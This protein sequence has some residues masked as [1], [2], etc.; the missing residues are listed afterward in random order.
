[1]NEEI[2]LGL[3]DRKILY[4]LDIDS[5]MPYSKIAKEVSMSKSTVKRRIEELVELGIIIGFKAMINPTRLGL[6]Y[7]RLHIKLHD[8]DEKNK[9]KL[10]DFLKVHPNVVWVVSSDGPYDLLVSFVTKGNYQMNALLMKLLNKFSNHID[11]YTIIDVLRLVVFNRGYWLKNEAVPQ[12]N[13]FVGFEETARF[14]TTEIDEIDIGIINVL[15]ENARASA[16]EIA[17]KLKIS[18]DSVL[19]RLRRLKTEGIITKFFLLTDYKKTGT[20]LYKTLV[21]LNKFNEDIEKKI[22][23]FSQQHPYIIDYVRTT[24][25]WEI[26]LDLEARDHEHYHEILSELRKL[27]PGVV[28]NYETL[29]VLKEHKFVLFPQFIGR[30]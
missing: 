22:L 19:Y 21:Y 15:A 11:H 8:T 29:Y 2:Q 6:N 1:M 13:Y 23:N 14:K 5:R 26:E 10:I 30:I 9:E 7:Y 16:M 20:A 18:S 24:A 12:A 25:P 4:Q 17:T 27:L 28:K 3:K